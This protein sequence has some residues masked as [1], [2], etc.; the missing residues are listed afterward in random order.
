MAQDFSKPIM[1]NGINILLTVEFTEDDWQT[2]YEGNCIDSTEY[3]YLIRSQK[4]GRVWVPKSS[5]RLKQ[6]NTKTEK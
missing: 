5:V 2:I 3:S 6:Q 4:Y 1:I